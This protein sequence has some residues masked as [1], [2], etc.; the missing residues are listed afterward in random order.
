VLSEKQIVS[1]KVLTISKKV[2]DQ[3]LKL[4]YHDYDKGI[5][6]E[7]IDHG[8]IL[9]WVKMHDYRVL[10]RELNG[11]YRLDPTSTV[12]GERQIFVV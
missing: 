6:Q 12:K 1:L 7:W 2:I 11:E 3:I 4:T 8:T 10:L 9:G 5:A